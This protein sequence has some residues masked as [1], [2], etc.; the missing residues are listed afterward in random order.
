MK[1]QNKKSSAIK[2]PAPKRTKTITPPNY[3]VLTKKTPIG[4]KAPPKKRIGDYGIRKVDTTRKTKKALPKSIKDAPTLLGLLREKLGRPP[5]KPKDK[6]TPTP[7]PIGQPKTDI[8]DRRYLVRPRPKRP[9]RPPSRPPVGVRPPFG[10]P[11]VGRPPVGVRPPVGRPPVGRPP[12]GRPPVGRPPVGVRPPFGRPPSRPPVSI[13]PPQVMLRPPVGIPTIS[14]KNPFDLNRKERVAVQKNLYKVQQEQRKFEYDRARQEISRRFQNDPARLRQ[15]LSNLNRGIRQDSV[16]R[17]FLAGMVGRDAL[18]KV[19]VPPR[20]INQLMFD[21]RMRFMPDSPRKYD[22]ERIFQMKQN[23]LN[24]TRAIKDAQKRGASRQVIMEIR[25]F[26]KRQTAN[27]NQM[28]DLKK[29]RLK[30]YRQLQ[31]NRR[32]QIV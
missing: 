6:K 4:K 21:R 2:K 1:P 19:G 23:Q 7:K 12:V 25:D 30:E 31:A 32:R 3:G 16:V 15:E 18:K 13:R 11:P 8:D 27:L 29:A 10:R 9:P 20:A 14:G 26:F 17:R 5:K 22:I 24:L 28:T